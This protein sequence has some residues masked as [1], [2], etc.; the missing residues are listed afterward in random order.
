MTDIDRLRNEFIE[1]MARLI[2]PPAME[3]EELREVI[4]NQARAARA[5]VE[6]QKDS[7]TDVTPDRIGWFTAYLYP[8]TENDVRVRRNLQENG[9]VRDEQGYMVSHGL[10][11]YTDIQWEDDVAPVRQYTEEQIRKALAKLYWFKSDAEE[12]IAELRRNK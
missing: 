3:G 8:R 2:A 4:G 11:A 7:N 10:D 12:L 6:A 5:L 9:R 1:A